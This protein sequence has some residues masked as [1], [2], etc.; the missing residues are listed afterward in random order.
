MFLRNSWYV[1]AWSKELSEKP[2]AR[3]L[4][5]EAIVMF[6]VGDG[7]VA[8][9]EDRCPHRHLPL[10][11]GKV[12]ASALR[13]AY[14][15][16]L[17]DRSG[18]CLEVPSQPTIPTNACVRSYPA[19]DRHGWVWVWMGEPEMA[20]PELIPDFH[21]LTDPAHAT[22]GKTNHVAAGYKLV[23]DNLVDLSHVGYVHTSTIGNNEF[24]QKGHLKVEPTDRGVR[25]KRLVPDVPP[26]PAYI[27]TGRLPEGKNIDRWQII[28]FIA[29]SFVHI[30]AGGA[31][32]GTGA[33]EGRY[34]HA[35]NFWIINAMTP[36]TETSTHYFWA[37]VR[38]FALGV[39]AVDKLLFGQVNEA[40]EED[41]VVLEA[42][43]K[44]LDE[45]EDSWKVA[46]GADA[47]SMQ[48]RRVLERLIAAET[49]TKAAAAS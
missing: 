48:A 18:A 20:D 44:V 7:E 8:A 24:T 4:L 45:R 34:D 29:P 39:E 21:R 15:G 41:R 28:D 37:S 33:L 31:E 30:H 3:R 9:L 11:M 49:K 22:V 17:F 35:L 12:E 13:C 16:M 23:T 27:K 5:N 46:L 1:G 14:H 43:Q 26:P 10:S 40:F 38:D 32:T 6:R 19:V 47:G 36:E 25:V 42:Q 2:L